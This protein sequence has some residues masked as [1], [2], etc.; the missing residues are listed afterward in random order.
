MPDPAVHATAQTVV[1]ATCDVVDGTRS[2]EEPT[3]AQD[4]VRAAHDRRINAAVAYV[5]TNT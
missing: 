2:I 3:S 4:A 5:S 1:V